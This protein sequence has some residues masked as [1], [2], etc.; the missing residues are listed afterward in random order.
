MY[1]LILHKS[2]FTFQP[3]LDYLTALLKNKGEVKEKIAASY[4]HI[5]KTLQLSICNEQENLCK[6]FDMGEHNLMIQ[7]NRNISQTTDNYL[8]QVI[9]EV[10]PFIFHGAIITKDETF[11]N[12]IG[13]SPSILEE[14]NISS[15][16]D[17]ETVLLLL[18]QNVQ[19]EET[20]PSFLSNEVV[21][22]TG[23]VSH[24][25]FPLFVFVFIFHPLHIVE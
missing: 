22:I 12:I 20:H 21:Q 7:G 10:I 3:I 4:H 13:L 1:L 11:L 15:C 9:E 2:N 8:A 5:F 17:F 18:K 16:L 14:V 25:S 24:S 19:H 23:E 6:H